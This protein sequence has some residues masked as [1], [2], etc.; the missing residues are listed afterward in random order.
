MRAKIGEW[1]IYRAEN[2]DNIESKLKIIPDMIKELYPPVNHF[3]YFPVS[4]V[5]KL[6]IADNEYFKD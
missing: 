1:E 6:K 5:N 2:P 4:W 3:Y